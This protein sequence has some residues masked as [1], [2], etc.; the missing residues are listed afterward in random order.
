MTSGRFVWRTNWQEHMRMDQPEATNGWRQERKESSTIVKALEW[1]GQTDGQK[2]NRTD[3]ELTMKTKI[4][5]WQD[6]LFFFALTTADASNGSVEWQAPQQIIRWPFA[7]NE[8]CTERPYEE[9][10]QTVANND[11]VPAGNSKPAAKLDTH[12]LT[13]GHHLY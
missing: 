6:F 8:S 7:A 9:N 4:I 3:G 13:N 11:C 12:R 10:K 2:I 1:L 5:K